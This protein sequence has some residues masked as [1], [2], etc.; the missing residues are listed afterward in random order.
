MHIEQDF[1]FV[2]LIFFKP[3]KVPFFLFLKSITLIEVRRIRSITN[4]SEMRLFIAVKKEKKRITTCALAKATCFKFYQE[5]SLKKLD[6]FGI[7]QEFF[8]C[9]SDKIIDLRS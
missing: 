7:L 9:F 1:F 6:D 2:S 5:F 4:H 8:I 3:P